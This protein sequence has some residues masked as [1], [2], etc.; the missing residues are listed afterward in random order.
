MN[1]FKTIFPWVI[2]GVF[3]LYALAKVYPHHETYREF[4]LNK[5]GAMPV[6]DGGRIRPLDSIARQHML[7]MSGK[8]E[9]EHPVDGSTQPAIL[10]L[11]EAVAT[12]DPYSGVAAEAQVFRIDNEETHQLPRSDRASRIAL[13]V[14][15]NRQ[16]I[17]Q[18]RGCPPRGSDRWTRKRDLFHAKVIELAG[19]LRVYQTL[20]MRQN[21]T[22][23][24][25]KP[26]STA[27]LSLADVD[28]QAIA[29]L[30]GQ[31]QEEAAR[32]VKAKLV[33]LQVDPEQVSREEVG[34][35]MFKEEQS[36][37]KE[38]ADQYRKA[39][40]PAA[41]A[42]VEILHCYQD[43]KPHGYSE[44]IDEYTSQ[45]VYPLNP[46][47]DF[48]DTTKFEQ[49]FNQAAPFILAAFL[50]V[51]AGAM[52]ALSWLGWVTPLRRAAIGLVVLAMALHFAG[53]MGRMYIMGRPLVFVTNL[54][55]SALL[56]GFAAVAGCLVVE[57]LFRNGVALIV[58]TIVGSTTV[59][60]AHHLSTDGNDTLAKLVA[61]LDT[62]YWLA[63]HVT[64]ITF[65]YAATYVAGLL[66]AVYILWGAF[67][68]TLDKAKHQTLGKMTY[69]VVCF[70]TLLSFV[71]TVLGGIWADQSWGRFWGWDPKEN[72]ARPYCALERSGPARTLGRDGEAT[73]SC[74]PHHRGDHGHD[75]E[76]VRH[77][78]TW[79]GSSQL[80]VQQDPG[81]WMPV[82]L[83][84]LRGTHC[85]R[86]DP[87][88]LLA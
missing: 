19:R 44:K 6:L 25:P 72:G 23:I 68:T 61:V 42:F 26:G 8:S 64:T 62:N 21:P 59:K 28:E 32:R 18:V 76:L 38:A 58:G 60:I 83:D 49:D 13:L 16:G 66:G 9:F 31:I 65:G 54:Y 70:A 75:L 22:L 11:L 17:R 20:T 46:D 36:L 37:R 63:S 40:S 88:S 47:P 41:A 85:H 3:A 5:F 87:D 1:T 82:Y 15:R 55:S 52:L 81:R 35:L 56:I 84:R 30:E 4:D 43:N 80:R 12:N 7:Y 39:F 53:L 86:A 10:W 71:G 24:S 67:G 29:G 45:Y 51:F 69:G 79:R 78:P 74:S 50:Y 34:R 57:L 2:I 77:Q 73:W 27:W 33:L 48:R 14:E